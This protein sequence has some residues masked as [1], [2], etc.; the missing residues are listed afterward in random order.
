MPDDEYTNYRD[1]AYSRLHR[2]PSAAR[3]LSY[4]D[5]NSLKSIDLDSTFFLEY[6]D[7]TYE[8][9]LLVET[10]LDNGQ[11]QRKATTVIQALAARCQ[12]LVEAYLVQYRWAKTPSPVDRKCYDIAELRPIRV[13]PSVR[14]YGWM[15]PGTYFPWLLER[16]AEG[17]ERIRRWNSIAVSRLTPDF[18]MF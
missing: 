4:E 3:F 8:P 11:Q 9:L 13:G 1:V 15:G 5:A 16:R 6:M 7:H 2:T 17:V 12:P 10:V 14:D 18:W